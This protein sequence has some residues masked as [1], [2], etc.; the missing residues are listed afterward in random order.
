[1]ETEGQNKTPRSRTARNSLT[2]VQSDSALLDQGFIRRVKSEVNIFRTKSL[3]LKRKQSLDSYSF[4]K[5]FSRRFWFFLVG[6]VWQA[7]T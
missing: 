2:S 5:F 7:Q 4:P 3:N 6:E 1:M